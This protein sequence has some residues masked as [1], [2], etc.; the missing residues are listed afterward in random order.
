MKVYSLTTTLDD[1]MDLP[2]SPPEEAQ[3]LVVGGAHIHLPYFPKLKYIFK[4]GVGTDNIPDLDGT[5]IALA[6]PSEKT[7][8]LIYDE[9]SSFAVGMILK[10][11]YHDVG[12]INFQGWKKKTRRS[13]RSKSVIVVGG[14]GNIGRRVVEKLKPMFRSVISYDTIRDDPSEISPSMGALLASADVITLHVPL[15]EDT[16]GMVSPH[17]LKEDVI[18]V[19]TARGPL[20]DEDELYSFLEHNPSATAAFDVFWEE[21]YTGK[22]NDLDNF[23]AT[24]HVASMSHGFFR[25]LSE[26]LLAL[27]GT[28]E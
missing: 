19:N 23:L 6:L 18:L 8:D 20:V 17:D 22:L 28:D 14:E 10:C 27:M 26:D 7:R 9:V 4:C 1:Y 12:E 21:P 3:V 11:H 25:G 15:T 5:G 16:N 13:L 2:S 24:P